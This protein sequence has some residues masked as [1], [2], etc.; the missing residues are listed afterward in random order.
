MTTPRE[1]EIAALRA[2]IL[3][4][5]SV[6]I[7]FDKLWL[8]W[9]EAAPRL[10]GSPN[11]AA[12]LDTAVRELCGDETI[13]FPVRAWDR[14]TVPIRPRFVTV[15]SARRAQRARPWVTFPWCAQL[16]W[17]A[18]LTTLS[19]ELF[20]DLKAVNDW[21]GAHG[22]PDTPVVP[23]RYRSAEVFGKEKR[24][25]Q[26]ATTVLFGPGRLTFDLLACV[27]IPPPLPAAVV[28]AGHDVLVVENS[29][30]YWVA[31]EA[32][33]GAGGHVIGAVAWGCG[34]S[35]PAQVSSLAVDIAG[36]GAVRGTVWYWGDYDPPGIEIAAAAA[37]AAEAV[38]VKP[39]VG[40]WS[41]MAD[42]PVQTAGTVDWSNADGSAWFGKD[43]WDR[44]AH[45]RDSRG[46]IAQELVPVDVVAVWAATVR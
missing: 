2:A 22:S 46:R 9:T 45:V 5:R 16:G 27:R 12:A 20:G 28:G 35:F 24:L 39:A 18:S 38:P 32:L 25:E 30:A 11:Q 42:L 29:D 40:L 19:D 43:L 21:L 14:S 13:E 7:E 44:L 34:K 31:V 17:A 10:A 33:R 1:S 8:L 4:T 36:R 3:A 26:L 15:P 23:V 41:A 37:R 6:R